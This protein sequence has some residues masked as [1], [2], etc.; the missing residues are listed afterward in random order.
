MQTRGNL[1]I[2]PELA[3]P[4]DMT[5]VPNLDEGFIKDIVCKPSDKYGPGYAVQSSI[6]KDAVEY[7]NRRRHL[8][9]QMQG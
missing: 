8:K 4:Y 3:V 7:L 5:I 1:F 6:C 9:T 2:K